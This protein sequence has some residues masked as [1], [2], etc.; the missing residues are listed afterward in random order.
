[1]G[2]HDV[3]DNQVGQKGLGLLQSFVSIGGLF[4]RII[5]LLQADPEQLQYVVVVV[6]DQNLFYP[7]RLYPSVRN[8]GPERNR[9]SWCPNPQTF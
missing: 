3:G 9:R 1:M 2:H 8:K 7:W 4:D 6:N 5:C